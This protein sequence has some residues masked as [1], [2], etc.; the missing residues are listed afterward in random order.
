MKTSIEDVRKRLRYLSESVADTDTVLYVDSRSKKAIE[1]K[2][3]NEMIRTLEFGIKH[4]A[5]L[6]NTVFDLFESI[7]EQG[8]P[9]QVNYAANLIVSE[10]T[11]K[12][13][14]PKETLTN[15]KRKLGRIKGKTTIATNTVGKAMESIRSSLSPSIGSSSLGRGSNPSPA[16]GSSSSDKEK[17]VEEAC[18]RIEEATYKVYQAD[19]IVKNY[20]DFSK[21]FN[22]DRII[23]E[24]SQYTSIPD[25]VVMI[26]KLMETYN[27]PENMQYS[28]AMESCWYGFHKNA[29]S[30]NQK[31]LVTTATDYFL[32]KGYNNSMVKDILENSLVVD[33]DDYN[34]DLSDG[35]DLEYITEEEPEELSEVAYVDDKGKK[36][37]KKCTCGGNVK[38]VFAGE[39]IF[40]CDKCGKYYGT[41]PFKEAKLSSADRKALKDSDYGLPEDKAYPMPDKSHVLAA[42]RMFN[43]VDPSKEKQ[44]ANAIKRKIKEFGMSDEV[45]VG[46]KNRFS[47]YYHNVSEMTL[48]EDTHEADEL[49]DKMK[50]LADDPYQSAFNTLRAN[51][52][53]DKMK[54]VANL[55]NG[56]LA[57]SSNKENIIARAINII[58]YVRV[59]LL[60]NPSLDADQFHFAFNE[61][62]FDVLTEPK[63]MGSPELG[64]EDYMKFNEML[65]AEMKIVW[66][67][68]DSFGPEG[69]ERYQMFSKSLSELHSQIDRV[70][71]DRKAVNKQEG[72]PPRDM[73]E[74]ESYTEM[75][76]IPLISDL[77][78]KRMQFETG[79]FDADK[80]KR[81]IMKDISLAET[82]ANLSKTNPEVIDPYE[83]HEAI[84][85]ILDA[86]YK[87]KAINLSVFDRSV[88]KEAESA[89]SEVKEAI[90]KKFEEYDKKM[91]DPDIMEEV[92]RLAIGNE[93]LESLNL[94][95][96]NCS[97]YAAPINEASFKNNMKLARMKLS[98]FF[99]KMN[100][101]QKAASKSIDVASNNF[102]K[103]IEKALTNDNREAVIK[104]SIMPSASKTVKLALASAVGFGAGSAIGA[105]TATAFLGPVFAI[106]PILGYVGM[107]KKFKAKERQ[108]I[109]DE[110]EIELK[111][112]QEY[113]DL[114]KQK[115]DLVALKQLLTI[116]K[117][118]ERQRQRIK[119]KMKIDYGQKYYDTD[120]TLQDLQ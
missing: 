114:A 12:L 3:I 59:I 20:N 19:R 16:G 1:G 25:T 112:V 35:E 98:R 2:S 36:V 10:W 79:F 52:N 51:D 42:I 45:K 22:I 93:I 53:P 120:V 24:N 80:Y 29:I 7:C 78:E 89:T 18:Q 103:G 108:M 6:E 55:I 84:Q 107:S 111:M 26:C 17:T 46:P 76:C 48:F 113:I 73:S 102:I 43:R 109:I 23:L 118:L 41:V 85:S 13:R 64:I 15:I 77:L 116:Q 9:S 50:K 90:D 8:N 86:H 88:L 74:E 94:I 37:P 27:I 99:T 47:K 67:I 62:L 87:N 4:N 57:H 49:Q 82:F 14:S 5:I 104:G 72:L 105:A 66:R 117:Q 61:I 44:L 21:R 83:L 39:P 60:P 28:M 70:I 96:T 81:M 101:K 71:E 34:G 11:Q 31:D 38:V 119:Y 115:N 30:F 92:N 68:I 32:S 56:P 65:E 97:I 69:N 63:A 33:P 100:D 40:K 95:Y 75:A 54:M 106:I 58:S 110:I 91:D